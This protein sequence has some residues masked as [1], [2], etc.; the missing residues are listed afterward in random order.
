MGLGL[1]S[2]EK[3][4]EAIL[5]FKK[6]E[7]QFASTYYNMGLALFRA[8]RNKEALDYFKRACAIEPDDAEFL[9]LLG[10]TCDRL[11]KYREGEKHLRRSIELAPNYAD[12]YYDLGNMFLKIEAKRPEAK[13]LLER[14]IELEP[15]DFWAHYCL[16]CWYALDGKKTTAFEWL[17]KTIEKGFRDRSWMDK[18]K[19]L[20]TLRGDPRYSKLAAKMEKRSGE[21]KGEGEKAGGVKQEEKAVERGH[22]TTSPISGKKRKGR[23]GAGPAMGKKGKNKAAKR[24]AR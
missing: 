14:A 22:N 21:G 23:K 5:C 12:S 1:M 18:D 19:D 4:E 20:E 10:Q 13:T 16:G 9:N 11:G 15:A 7:K 17:E 24:P 8:D 6:N 2:Q 3:Y